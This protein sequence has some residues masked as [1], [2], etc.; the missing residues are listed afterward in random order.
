MLEDFSVRQGDDDYATK[1]FFTLIKQVRR[2]STSFRIARKELQAAAP[3]ICRH[4]SRGGQSSSQKT[5]HTRKWRRL[6]GFQ[7]RDIVLGHLLEAN[8]ILA[9]SKSS[10]K[11]WSAIEEMTESLSAV[12]A[13]KEDLNS[14]A[15]LHSDAGDSLPFAQDKISGR[16]G[17][18][19]KRLN[20]IFRTVTHF[21]VSLR[22][23]SKIRTRMAK[24]TELI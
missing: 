1:N 21:G 14:N 24:P 18:P 4:F 19:T 16:A 8:F 5:P 15:A 3:E 7:R 11:P 9:G 6:I 22:V 12:E 17:K 10:V 23:K 13:S 2:W 20:R